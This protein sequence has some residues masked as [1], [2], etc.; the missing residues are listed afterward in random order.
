MKRKYKLSH[1]IKTL[2]HPNEITSDD[3]LN[4]FKTNRQNIK[5]IHTNGH[6]FEFGIVNKTRFW[7]CVT[8]LQE[9]NGLSCK[10][11]V[12]DT[13]FEDSNG[14][15]Y[16]H[17]QISNLEWVYG[18]NKHCISSYDIGPM[19][20]VGFKSNPQV[21]NIVDKIAETYKNRYR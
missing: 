17:E 3:V 5:Q 18:N 19:L 13:W 15:H 14:Q 1:V 2:S 9:K 21:R 20:S 4:L 6:R 11:E 7:K 10:A 12:L 8:Y 16:F